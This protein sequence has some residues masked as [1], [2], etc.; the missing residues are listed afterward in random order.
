MLAVQQVQVSFDSGF[1]KVHSHDTAAKS[2]IKV[3]S[4]DLDYGRSSRLAR[5]IGIV[6]KCRSIGLNAP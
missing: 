5:A 1:S 6:T 4:H 3:G 2:N